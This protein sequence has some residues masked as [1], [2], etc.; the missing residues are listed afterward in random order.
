MGS[1]VEKRAMASSGPEEKRPPHRAGEEGREELSSE[2][3]LIIVQLFYPR[4][5]PACAHKARSSARAR[6]KPAQRGPDFALQ[7]M[8]ALVKN[9]STQQGET[10]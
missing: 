1:E 6:R 3:L 10:C 2:A 7:N 5:G 9:R 8:G 4:A